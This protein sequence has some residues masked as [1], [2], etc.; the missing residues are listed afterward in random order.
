MLRLGDPAPIGYG[1]AVF[2]HRRWRDGDDLAAYLAQAVMGT[3]GPEL[4]VTPQTI[5]PLRLLVPTR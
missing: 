3:L 2:F 4:T 1:E 5:P